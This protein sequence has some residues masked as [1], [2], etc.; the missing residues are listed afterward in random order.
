MNKNT[1]SSKK[2][3]TPFSSERDILDYSLRELQQIPNAKVI[4]QGNRTTIQCP[5][6]NGIIRADIKQYSHGE[7]R[8]ISVTPAKNTNNQQEFE[9]TIMQRLSEGYSQSDVALTMGISQSRVSQI[10]KKHSK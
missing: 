3:I 5:L 4:S 9:D 8:T 7:T 6:D 2:N 10:K 1:I